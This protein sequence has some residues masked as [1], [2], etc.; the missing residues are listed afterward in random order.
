MNDEALTPRLLRDQPG[1]IGVA[2]GGGVSGFPWQGHQRFC[3]CVFSP[4][5]TYRDVHPAAKLDALL[6]CVL[7]LPVG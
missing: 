4:P 1:V 7:G 2:Q 3:G 6:R 5:D